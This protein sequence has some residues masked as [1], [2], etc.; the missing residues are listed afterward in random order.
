MR[1][2]RVSG[3]KKK[4]VSFWIFMWAKTNK[5]TR[6]IAIMAKNSKPFGK[7]IFPKP[8][9]DVPVPLLFHLSSMLITPAV[10]VVNAKKLHR[11][12]PT[13]GANTSIVFNNL[14]P[15]STLV[16]KPCFTCLF[17]I[18]SVPRQLLLLIRR[19]SL[20]IGHLF[21][22]IFSGDLVPAWSTTTA[23]SYRFLQQGGAI[24]AGRRP[25]NFLSHLLLTLY[26]EYTLNNR[27]KI[28][29]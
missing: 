29:E 19:R 28:N 20:G 23:I 6:H 8:L 16:M 24:H 27:G 1:G 14:P 2:Y 18:V 7:I 17:F 12:F 5:P 4:F 21:V 13:T 26:H 11:A 3:E 15:Y 25:L 10:D 9:C 22:M